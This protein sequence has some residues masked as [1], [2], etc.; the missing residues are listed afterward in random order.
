MESQPDYKLHQNANYWLARGTWH[1]PTRKH[2]K[3]RQSVR[4]P[5]TGL[6]TSQM[7]TSHTWQQGQQE[8]AL[9][10]EQ[11]CM[12]PSNM[13]PKG[14]TI[15][16]W[17]LEVIRI[18]VLLG[19][20]LLLLRHSNHSFHPTQKRGNTEDLQKSVL[21]WKCTERKRREIDI[22]CRLHSPLWCLQ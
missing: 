22:G 1:I 4:A 15:C 7:D 5:Y 14:K 11:V 9:S 3:T 10:T 13:W 6:R 19:E 2:R 18:N 17:A 8:K 21:G 12:R 20:P 16:V